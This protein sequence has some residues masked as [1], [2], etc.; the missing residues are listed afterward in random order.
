MT[1]E[2]IFENEHLKIKKRKGCKERRI[3]GKTRYPFIH[4]IFYCM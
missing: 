3:E 4:K 1:Y 2:H